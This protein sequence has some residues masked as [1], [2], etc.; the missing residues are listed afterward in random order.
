MIIKDL[1]QIINKKFTVIII[2]SGF[3]GLTAALKL[4]KKGIETLIIESGGLEF[5]NESNKFLKVYTEGDYKGDFTE[6]RTRKF[7]GT[8]NL[9]GGNCNPMNKENLFDWPIKKDDLDQYNDEARE[10]LYLRKN[11]FQEKL[12]DNL[13]IYNLVWSKIKI[14][15]N[16]YKHIEKSKLIHLSLKTSFLNFE[17]FGKKI[18]SL[19]CKKGGNNFLLNASFFI[20]ACGGIENS[21]LLLWA[22]KINKD[23][24]N[25][26]LPIGE[27]YMHHPYFFIGQGIVN[28]KKLN[29][30]FEKNRIINAPIITCE[31]N[32]FVE[33]NNI[34]LQNKQILNSGIYIN[35]KETEN[36]DFVKQLRCMAPKFVKKLYDDNNA[37]EV[38]EVEI[39]TLQEQKSLKKNCIKLTKDT[40]PNGIPLAKLFWK[41]DRSEIN[42]TRIIIEELA[43]LFIKED[44]GRL[45]LAEHLYNPEIKYDFISGNHQMGGTRIGNSEE[46]SVVDKNLKVHGIENLF[47]SGSSVFRSSGHC[48]PTFTIV[49]LSLR[50]ADNI[51]NY[52]NKI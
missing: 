50:L 7:G 13:N 17:N 28:Y 42:N 23:L 6:N 41:K 20:L 1:N 8:S 30:Y 4:E 33:A 27:Y 10:F 51:I 36:N 3:A 29:S 26:K 47:V 40:D 43:K 35:F 25:I 19:N 5:N 45:A 48:H 32:L 18:T 52:T 11:F 9:W 44:I 34:F 39:Q 22:K 49:Q 2:G 37:N 38:Y 15:E 12:S 21:R 14:G 46:D 24:F 16:Y 31:N